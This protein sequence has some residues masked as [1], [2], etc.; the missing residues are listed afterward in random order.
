MV[1]LVALVMAEASWVHSNVGVDSVHFSVVTSVVG[2]ELSFQQGSWH[3]GLS[4]VKMLG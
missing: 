2:Q 4:L 3:D 1:H